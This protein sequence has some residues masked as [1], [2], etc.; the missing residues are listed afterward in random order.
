MAFAGC[1]DSSV[2]LSSAKNVKSVLFTSPSGVETELKLDDGDGM[3][4]SGFDG[5]NIHKEVRELSVEVTTSSYIIRSED[6]TY[7][8]PTSYTLEVLE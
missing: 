8:V 1:F 3:I 6:K 7:Y 2:S 4:T 5:K